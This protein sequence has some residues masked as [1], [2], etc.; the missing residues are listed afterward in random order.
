MRGDASLRPEGEYNVRLELANVLRDLAHD[1]VG[2]ETMKLAIGVVQHNASGHSQNL[3][4]GGKLPASHRSKLYVIPGASAMGRSLTRRQTKHSR[5]HSAITI[6]PQRSAKA[7]SF[8]IGMGRDAHHAQH[9]GDCTATL[10]RVS[11]CRVA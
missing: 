11:A 5:F 6:Q 3:A 2:V 9:A 1:G 7:S 8:I 10:L 4:R